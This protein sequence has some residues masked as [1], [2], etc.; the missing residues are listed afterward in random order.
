MIKPK[1]LEVDEDNKVEFRCSTLAPKIIWFFRD[2][3]TKKLTRMINDEHSLI[4]D[5]VQSYHAGLY[6]CYCIE[7]QERAFLDIVRLIVYGE[8]LYI[9][10]IYIYYIYIYYIYNIYIIYI[11]Y[12]L[13]I[14]YIYYIYIYNKSM[15]ITMF[16]N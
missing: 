3:R 10:Y 2:S 11:Y 8:C 16:V 1:C 9:Y 6:Y 14:Y 4:I 12:I 5:N 7:N 15:P 13:Y